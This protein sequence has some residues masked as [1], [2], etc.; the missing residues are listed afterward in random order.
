MLWMSLSYAADPD[1]IR[2]LRDRDRPAPAVPDKE[3]WAARV[4]VSI[5]ADF[6]GETPAWLTGREVYLSQ[7]HGWIWYDTLGRFSTQRGL[8]WDTVEDIHNP[9]GLNQY[10]ARY[11][12]NA[13]ASVFTVKERDQN[14]NWAI[15]DN[16]G[17]GYSESG[18]G[19]VDGP[20]GYI[21]AGPWPYGE[22]P[23]DT[24]T[25]RTFPADGGAVATWIPEVPEDG[26]YAVYVSWDSDAS[27]AT[28]AHYRITHPGGVIDRRFDQTVHGST[29]QYVETLWLPAGLPLTVE[30]IGDSKQH[31]SL[32][33]DAVR[34]G[35]GTGVVERHGET[36]GRPRWEEGAILATQYNGAPTSVYDPYGEGD[37]SDP[38]SRS[39]WAA[40]EHPSSKDALYLS[41][42][43]NAYTGDA[44]GTTTYSYEDSCSGGRAVSGS[45]DLSE[46][47]QDEL[48]S[49]IT[50][51]WDTNWNDR[52][53]NTDCFAEVNP[54]HNSEMPSVLV[55]LAFHDN[56]DDAWYL[57]QP[58][59]RDDMSRA[60]YHGIVRYFADRDGVPPSFLPEPPTAV[61]LLHVDG[62][63]VASWAPGLS[64][65]PYGD[66]P[67]DWLVQTSRDGRS[68]DGGTAT[69]ATSLALDVPK[70]TAVYVRVVAR[71][72]GGVSFPSEVVAARR[73]FDGEVPIL[74]VSAFDRLDGALLSWDPLPG[75]GTSRKMT[76]E[77][78][79]PQ[80][81]A[82]VHGRSIDALGWPFDTASD[83]AL[84]DLSRYQLV[85]WMTGEESTDDETF[86]SA[87]QAVV[88]AYVEG[89][90]ALWASGAEMLWDLD[91]KGSAEDKAFALDILGATMASDESGTFG[92]V[93]A[94]I[95]SGLDASFGV[96]DGAPYPVEWADVLGTDRTAILTYDTGG[97]AAAL[98][99]RVATFGFPFETIGDPATRDTIVA[100]LLPALLPDYVP[101][102]EP[103]DDTDDTDV[104]VAG[105]DPW[106]RTPLSEVGCGCAHGSGA[107][108]AAVFAL[109]CLRRRR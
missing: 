98:G 48:M 97:V 13:G 42:H 91:Y 82:A 27:N 67:T 23:F 71:N 8:A 53:T 10:L 105:E 79:N 72:A 99:D 29:W 107:P 85:V 9:E 19:F 54:S 55:E 57:L 5:A 21:D 44:R 96:D 68:W 47:V 64:G 38:A 58:R 63:L 61:T 18:A 49:S 26:N 86:S 4:P 81:V 51:L 56:E 36:T 31:K 41:W 94:D 40:W 50:S 108:W 52:G 93:G 89:G 73:S 43:S 83:E 100:R 15:A 33:A 25:T 77:H 34:V 90:G 24:G 1:E 104:T 101:G 11:L 75:V 78:V 59:F 35:G 80:D 2:A 88:R 62:D 37:G 74:L 92:L 39:R 20:S 60:M 95:L 17:E 46:I 70:G 87:Q 65:E 7:C 16:D 69:S 109:W 76:L 22:D 106:P 14:P 102:T 3:P 84:P 32:S 12:E 30:L 103:D 28:D 6:P 45:H 66:P